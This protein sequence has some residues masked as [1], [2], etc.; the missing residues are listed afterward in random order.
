MDQVLDLEDLGKVP[1]CLDHTELRPGLQIEVKDAEWSLDAR[2]RNHVRIGYSDLLPEFE[3]A[4]MVAVF[5]HRNPAGEPFCVGI[6]SK[7]DRR[8]VK[9]L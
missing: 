5:L 1:N 2:L 8:F 9:D 6:G 7:A 3:E 4:D